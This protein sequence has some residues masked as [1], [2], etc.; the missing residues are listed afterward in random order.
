MEWRI[1]NMAL[2]SRD[3]PL[4]AIVLASEPK[5]ASGPQPSLFD[6]TVQRLEPV[7]SGD[8][9][10]AVV[11]RGTP[12]PANAR[13]GVGRKIPARHDR[14]TAPNVLLALASILE[15]SPEALVLVTPAHHRV[16]HW[17]VYQAGLLEA[18]AALTVAGAEAVAFGMTPLAP[19]AGCGWIVPG[20]VRS[21]GASR[22]R[23]VN[24]FTEAPTVDR[25]ARLFR[26]GGLWNTRVVMAPARVLARLYAQHLPD[27]A[28]V[29][30]RYQQQPS[31]N[32]GAFLAAAYAAMP[33]ADFFRDLVSVAGTFAVYTWPA[34][35]GWSDLGAPDREWFVWNWAKAQTIGTA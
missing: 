1:R 13:E 33:A 34:S 17:R 3:T 4:W 19:I 22:L 31:E 30:A 20:A 5:P 27:L 35:L 25:A 18:A 6:Q 32:R 7:V 23:E 29:M 24:E 2:D 12:R 9:I 8:R 21:A 26:E 10:V 11:G 14:G 16:H 15:A 28:D